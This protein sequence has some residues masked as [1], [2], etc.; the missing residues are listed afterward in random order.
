M[1][2]ARSGAIARRWRRDVAHDA[3]TIELVLANGKHATVAFNPNAVGATLT[4]DTNSITLGA[5]IDSLPE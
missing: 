5:G 3:N 2:P 4:L 1:D